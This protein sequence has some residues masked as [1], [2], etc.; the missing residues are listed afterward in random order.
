[1][2][3]TEQGLRSTQTAELGV[4]PGDFTLSDTDTDTLL[5]LFFEQEQPLWFLHRAR[6]RDA[7]RRPLEDPHRAHSALISIVCAIA[8]R[9]ANPE[10]AWLESGLTDISLS[11]VNTAL[12]TGGIGYEGNVLQ[13]LQARVLLGGVLAQTGRTLQS[14]AVL[15]G[16]CALALALGLHG[17]NEQT[18]PTPLGVMDPIAQQSLPSPTD[19][20]SRA[21]RAGAFWITTALEAI[22]AIA[23]GSPPRV[24][25]LRYHITTPWP[26][27]PEL[28]E[29]H[30][31]NML[32]SARG[33]QA[34]R[35]FLDGNGQPP[36]W[37]GDNAVELIVSAAYLLSNSSALARSMPTEDAPEAVTF[38]ARANA[39]TLALGP[40]LLAD[41]RTHPAQVL[42][43]GVTLELHT[44]PGDLRAVNA[45]R[46]LAAAAPALL[47]PSLAP[48]FLELAIG[49]RKYV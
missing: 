7:V 5:H 16:A 15:E 37:T 10:L 33:P 2:S 35:S 13:L 48:G 19:N 6:F 31:F 41:I 44:N 40:T 12:N 42:V 49:V 30:Q 43:R 11:T 20:V 36:T 34:A 29:E 32:S 17:S 22:W 1:M 26:V 8:T 38:E 24:G 46:A 25:F 45:A 28:A 39:F 14:A 9:Y 4:G 18:A 21:E 27:T 23:R 3:S 47:S